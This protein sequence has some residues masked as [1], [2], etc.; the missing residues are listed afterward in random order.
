[1]MEFIL[2]AM[3]ARAGMYKDAGQVGASPV[4]PSFIPAEHIASFLQHATSQ[5]EEEV[6][7]KSIRSRRC[8][9]GGRR[10]CR[11]RM[12]VRSRGLAV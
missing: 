4:P 5:D 11:R 10:S 3:E 12:R 7:R 1:M 2:T 8:I 6:P 9:I